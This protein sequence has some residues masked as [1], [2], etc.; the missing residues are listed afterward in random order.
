M[1]AQ[2]RPRGRSNSGGSGT[3]D[4]ARRI[5]AYCEQRGMS[6]DELATRAGMAPN[7]LRQIERLE[8]D[9]DPDA[10]H[11]LATALGISSKELMEGRGDA[12]PGQNPPA[13]EPR[14]ARLTTE[15]CRD[16]LGQH[17]VG[18][19]ALPGEDGTLVLPVNYLVDGPDVIY[20]TALGGAADPVA[21]SDITLE[22]D[23]LS[24]RHGDG[25]S[26]L[27]FGRAEI[28]AD[29]G[30]IE[31][32]RHRPGARPWAGGVRDRW[33]RIVPSRLTGRLITTT[34]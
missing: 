8:S 12:P 31:R 10:L 5:A 32:Y 14:L 7:Y 16:R 28:L 23:H 13:P 6:A 15:E 24:E 34:G 27:V 22:A 33:V 19:V 9:F 20:R 3:P 11:R 26:V 2:R 30:A 25:W 1:A 29:A 21:G 17:G 4:L 18:R